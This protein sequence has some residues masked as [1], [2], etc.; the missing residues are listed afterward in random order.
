VQSPNFT[1]RRFRYGVCK[2]SL[3]L[4]EGLRF[5]DAR[6]RPEWVGSGHSFCR[7]ERQFWAN[8]NNLTRGASGSNGVSLQLRLEDHEIGKIGRRQIRR[9]H[10]RQTICGLA[11]DALFKPTMDILANAFG[12][13]QYS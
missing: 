8:A 6:E 5:D 9:R 12:L 10:P 3:G 4:T 7:S 1:L 2:F 11:T 13:S